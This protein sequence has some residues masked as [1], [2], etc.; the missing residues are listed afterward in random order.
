MQ[1]SVNAKS[2]FMQTVKN[3]ISLGKAYTVESRLSVVMGRK[4]VTVMQK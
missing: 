1:G 3:G 2:K 4:G